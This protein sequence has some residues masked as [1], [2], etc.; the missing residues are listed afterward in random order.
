MARGEAK[1]VEPAFGVLQGRWNILRCP[2]RFWTV[3][4]MK[5]VMYCCIILHNMMVEE[6]LSE[7]E[8]TSLDSNA[9]EEEVVHFGH[10]ILADDNFHRVQGFV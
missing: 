9:I 4:S 3:R 2:S 10:P 6:K 1:D 8:I 7:V 5:N